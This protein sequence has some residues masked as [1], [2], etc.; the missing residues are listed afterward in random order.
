[1]TPEDAFIIGGERFF[2]REALHWYITQ[3]KVPIRSYL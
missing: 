3:T 2:D 1:M